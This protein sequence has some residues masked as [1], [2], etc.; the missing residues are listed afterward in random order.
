MFTP[1]LIIMRMTVFQSSGVYP[2][3]VR[4]VRA[5][6]LLHWAS[7]SAFPLAS[8]ISF[9][10]QAGS[11]EQRRAAAMKRYKWISIVSPR[12]RRGIILAQRPAR[13]KLE[14]G[15][16]GRGPT[17]VCAIDC[18]CS[19]RRN[20]IDCCSARLSRAPDPDHRS[21]DPRRVARHHRAL[22]RRRAAERRAAAGGGGKPP[23]RQPEHRRRAG[24]E[25]RARRLHM[26]ARPRQRLLR[27]PLPGQTALRSAH[28]L[29][30]RYRGGAHPVSARCSSERAGFVGG[31]ADRLRESAARRAKLRL[32]RQRQPAAPWCDAVPRSEERRVG[33]ECRSRWS[34]YH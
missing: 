21:A 14:G 15:T 5:W 8:G 18:L 1:W 7:T 16:T 17:G 10:A 22:D 34:P 30:P 32:L 26:A 19:A 31:G 11:T 4:A 23:R 33:K 13:G 9:W 6:Q 27:Q 24:G 25:E 3:P 28:R 2:E 12:L 29:R 20:G